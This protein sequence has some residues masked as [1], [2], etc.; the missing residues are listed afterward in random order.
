MSRRSPSARA[1][2]RHVP[3]E[4]PRA[5]PRLG[6]PRV[7]LGAAALV[8][9]GVLAYANSLG[10]VF[11]IDDFYTIVDNPDIREP[12]STSLVRSSWGESAVLGRPVV[13]LTFAINY[14]LHGLD[15]RGYH[16]GNI[17]V[18]L[19]CAL[20]LFALIRRI[21]HSLVFAFVCASLWMLHPLNSEVINY[22]SQRTE[23]MM[24]L[25][26]L[27]TIYASIRA[28]TAP[29]AWPWMLAALA[30][31]ALGVWSKQSMV[32]IVLAVLL[33]DYTLFYDSLKAALRS[34][35]RF[36]LGVTAASLGVG[37]ITTYLSP[38]SRAVGFGSG[39]S[40]WIY[41]LNQSVIITRYIRLAIWPSD[42]VTEYGYPVSY[43]LLD[44]L[45]SMIFV[46][47]LFVLAVV[48]LRYRR[49]LGL[50][51]LW[52]FLT[53]GVTSSVA[54][55]ATEVGAERRMYLP[56]IALVV[57]GVAPFAQL[58][59][60]L[61]RHGRLPARAVTAGC[62]VLWAAT[63]AALGATT[64]ARNREYSSGLLLAS[65]TFERWPNAYTRH[66][67]AEELL[68]AG[69]REEAIAQ[70]RE[71]NRGDARAHFT[72]G[73]VLFQ[74][75]HLAEAREQ[76][77]T[78]VRLEPER[79]EAVDAR[80]MMGRALLAEGRLDEAAEQFRM[81]LQMQSSF[82]DAHLGLAEVLDAQQRYGEAATRYRAYF[83]AGG[84]N[85]G[86]WL[87]FGIALARAGRADEAIQVLRRAVE[88]FPESHLGHRSL[89]AM[90]LE[91]NDVPAAAQHAQR[92]V[93]LNPGDSASRDLLGVTLAAQGRT[94]Q[95]AFE[96]REALRLDSTND[97]AREHLEQVLRP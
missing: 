78:F 32:T 90:L 58:S 47:G 23:S 12:L 89:A 44:V 16:V 36:Y 33:V 14:S 22:I 80:A 81:V 13:A 84:T 35:W 51:G 34:R 10:G 3:E 37:L 65:V 88:H 96:F 45:P 8:L 50:V 43:S 15:V 73:R 83:T 27:L 2:I 18:H 9:L 30:T 26:Y 71:A 91:R 93:A 72:L 66:W 82:F 63:A 76:L 17:A 29:R 79:V 97:T 74:D 38:T 39:P 57:L 4:A 87:P 24:A 69:R 86:A 31:S 62:V 5:R 48:A 46:G 41:L 49:K 42:L 7:W 75:G 68:I 21:S 54:P 25:F 20:V 95:A 70:L 53:L 92:A 1:Q 64:V 94:E 59:R 52:F 85:A 56:L 77:Q 67:L 6:D 61:T 55:I 60:H 40:P 28:H 19:L 11:I